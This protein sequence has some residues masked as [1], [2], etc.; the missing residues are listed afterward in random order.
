MNVNKA[1]MVVI[2][3]FA[4]AGITYAATSGTESGS[5]VVSQIAACEAAQRSASLSADLHLKIESGY[6]SVDI[7]P[8]SCEKSGGFTC[9]VRWRLTR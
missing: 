4:L 9:I 6:K 3:M 1:L 7:S 5:S 8:C 2:G